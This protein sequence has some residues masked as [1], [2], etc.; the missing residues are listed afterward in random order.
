VGDGK[1]CHV[2]RWFITAPKA[3]KDLYDSPALANFAG[4]LITAFSV[5]LLLGIE[6]LILAGSTTPFWISLLVALAI[7][8]YGHYHMN[9]GSRFTKEGASLHYM[10]FSAE[11]GKPSRNLVNSG[12]AVL[13]IIL[14][15]VFAFIGSGKR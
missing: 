6:A 5:V 9:A 3:V 13:I 7:M 10:P 1:G 14:K 12:H 15:A 8:S 2:D 4:M 11:D